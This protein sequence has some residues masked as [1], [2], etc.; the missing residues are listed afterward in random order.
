MD[1]YFDDSYGQLYEKSEKGKYTAF[2]YEDENGRVRHS[3]ILR[4]IPGTDWFDIVTPYG[5]GG[6]HVIEEYGSREELIDRF[7]SR[8]TEFCE[9]HRIVSE[10]V[11]FHPIEKNY[12]DFGSFYNAAFDRH[13]VGTNLEAYC[14]PVA[15]EFSKGCKKSIRQ[16]LHK[17]VSSK[18]TLSPMDISAFE[19]V[20]YSTMER[21]RASDYYYFDDQYFTELRKAC[22]GNLLLVEALYEGNIIAAGLYMLSDGVIH[23]HLSGTLTQYLSLSPAYILRYAATLWGKE[24]GY[25]LI[26]HG[27]GRSND[28]KDGLFLFKKQF[29]RNTLF[30]FYVGRKIWNREKYRSLCGMK[31]T[32][33]HTVE[34]EFFPLYRKRE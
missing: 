7:Y 16:A 20:Y 11:R 15:S 9:D 31:N 32:D 25:R 4:E 23:I 22:K 18:V 10:F 14:D 19:N 29:G 13:T 2:E 6:P 12:I 26:H 28:E 34:N 27:G 8:F 5:Y 1:I 24:N 21:N 30:D 17:G 3:F 33:L